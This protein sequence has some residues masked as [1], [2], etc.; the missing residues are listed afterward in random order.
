MLWSLLTTVLD[1]LAPEACVFCGADRGDVPW[2]AATGSRAPGL[3]PWD[4]P[5]V[6]RPCFEIRGGGRLAGEVAGLPLWSPLAA[7]AELAAA[8]GA[9][10]YRGIRGLGLPLGAWL[11]PLLTVV[12]ADLADPVLV[13]VPLHRRRRRERGFDQVVQLACLAGQAAG[14]PIRTDVLERRRATRQQASC[15]TEGPARRANVSGVFACRTPRRPQDGCLILLDDLAT[16]G[17]TL[18]A[19]AAVLADAGWTVAAC[20]ALGQARRLGPGAGA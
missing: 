15:A 20:A 8:V 4:S 13:P 17:A 2:F 5:H 3:R 16:T 6:C 7:S 18:A 11:A 19:A 12:A 9:W 1:A 14:L 10:K